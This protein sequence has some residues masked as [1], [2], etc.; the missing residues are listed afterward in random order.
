MLHLAAIIS[1]AL[2]V[3]FYAWDISH[4]HWTYILLALLGLFLWC[5][6]GKWDRAL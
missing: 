6:S 4:G 5:V 3:I 2:S 1:F